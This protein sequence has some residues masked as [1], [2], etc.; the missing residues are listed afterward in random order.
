MLNVL[1]VGCILLTRNA[2][3]GRREEPSDIKVRNGQKKNTKKKKKKKTAVVQPHRSS[4]GLTEAT[5]KGRGGGGKSIVLCRKKGSDRRFHREMTGWISEPP[6]PRAFRI[7]NISR[8]RVEI[9][10]DRKRVENPFFSSRGHPRAMLW[11][12][13][14]IVNWGFKRGGKV[15]KCIKAAL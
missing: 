11:G 9:V 5:E 8:E 10:E 6:R 12:G 14:G 13:G 1:L 7:H 2:K 3:G 4:K 15:R